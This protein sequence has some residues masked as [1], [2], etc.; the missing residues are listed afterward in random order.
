MRGENVGQTNDAERVTAQK[1][2]KGRQKEREN[3]SVKQQFEN[4]I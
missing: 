4:C 2:K 3:H 1:K